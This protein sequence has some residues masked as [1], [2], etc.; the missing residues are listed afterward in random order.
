MR[1]ARLLIPA[2]MLAFLPSSPVSPPPA[3]LADPPTRVGRLS[4]AAGA[5]SLRP[6][7]EDDWADA[8]L[9]YPLSTGDHLW[10]DDDGRAEV[11]LG[12]TAIRLARYTAFGFLTLDDDAVQVRLSQGSLQVR[13]R[14]LEEDDSFE[15]D[16][17]NGAISL[18]RPGTYVVDVDP[19][20]DTT[21]L[22]VRRGQAEV[23]AAGSAF[24][25]RSDQA[26]TLVGTDWPTYD[27][28]DPLGPDAWE[29][30][31][32]SRDR[33][34]DDARSTSYVSREMP[35]Y[36]DLDA[37]G[38]W[39]VTPTYGPVWVPRHAVAGWAPYRYGHW[40]WVDPWGWTWIDDAPWG[41]AP[42]HYGRWIYS[43]SYWAWVPGPVYVR[44]V[45]APALVAWFGGSNF[46]IGISFGGGY[47]W[48]PLGYGEPF[49]PWYGG[50]RNYFQRVNITNT[51]ITNI[52]YITN[53]YY[54][55][56]RDR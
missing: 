37:Y 31:C 38:T 16:T 47:G 27:V 14:N 21:I 41:F 52:T 10:T 28:H 23:T 44:P 35:G 4:Y 36:E 40:S 15:I 12:S 46:S 22:T 24:S 6:G 26:A 56:D 13:L 42:F 33:R 5:V 53:N 11:T 48:C 8:T 55:R 50:S 30:W 20:G 3:G 49:I 18:L 51:R 39:R 34:A 45:Y 17:P 19:T 43:G 29:N 25:V 9:N 1:T 54:D 32:A 2:V 7:G